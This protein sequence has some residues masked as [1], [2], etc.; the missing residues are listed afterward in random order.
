MYEE[1]GGNDDNNYVRW[2]WK[3]LL[4]G[5][6]DGSRPPPPSLHVR[7][8][9]NTTILVEWLPL[10]P[11]VSFT[12]VTISIP[13]ISHYDV[14]TSSTSMPLSFTFSSIPGINFNVSIFLSNEY[15][16]SDIV[17]KS[18]QTQGI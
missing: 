7:A 1:G 10:V 3:Y 15:G 4:I 12:N 11:I 17:Y 2:H 14:I 8:L 13:S 18:T 6:I 9:G 16:S 5:L